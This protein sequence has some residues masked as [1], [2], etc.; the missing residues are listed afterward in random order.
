MLPNNG[1]SIDHKYELKKEFETEFFHLSAQISHDK[2]RLYM[3]WYTERIRLAER[4]R[5]EESIPLLEKI[6]A[7]SLAIAAKL[8][9][10]R[11]GKVWLIVGACSIATNLFVGFW[12]LK[13]F[14]KSIRGSSA[15][16][17]AIAGD[18]WQSKL[19]YAQYKNNKL[20]NR[21]ELCDLEEIVGDVANAVYS[22][23]PSFP[24][25]DEIVHV[26]VFTIPLNV[27][28]KIPFLS[29]SVTHH[30]IDI[31][32]RLGFHITVEKGLT[33]ILIQSCPP[34]N[35]TGF[36]SP[37]IWRLRDG[38]ERSYLD[39]LR[40]VADIS[41][42]DQDTSLFDIIKWIHRDNQ[43]FES[44]HLADSNCQHFASNVFMKTLQLP[45]PNAAKFLSIYPFREYRGCR[46]GRV[47]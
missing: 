16:R 46:I 43:L 19:V 8:V 1:K 30:F 4:I 2:M 9:G 31:E 26:K 34:S 35:K 7:G 37:V 23:N 12:G 44:Y 3:R 15:S 45:Y 42:D 10:F 38:E 5:L 39:S 25:F 36:G 47:I 14:V 32:T 6:R 24:L 11:V 27:L 13:R 28:S 21:F 29:K 40:I 20:V 18:A 33:F 17:S 22:I 41:I